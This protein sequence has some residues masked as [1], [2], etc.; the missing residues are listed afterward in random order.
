MEKTIIILLTFLFFIS[1]GYTPIYLNKTMNFSL[2]EITK[3]KNDR[4]N[5][6]IE[7]RLKNLSNKKSEKKVS[8]NISSKKEIKIVAKDSRGNP[9][10]YEMVIKI[11]V[12]IVY[13]Q[14]QNLDKEF[15]QGF[16]YN[17]NENKFELN[18]Y[19]KEIEELLID[20][21]FENLIKYLSKI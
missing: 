9:S 2:V 11:Q 3:S 16:S 15:S 14:K 21:F 7:K 17:T 8:L 6:K 4:L 13:D 18:Q 20:K 19:E 5:S 10:R 1:C 12:D